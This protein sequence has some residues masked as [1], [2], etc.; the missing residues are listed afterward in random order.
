MLDLATVIGAV[1]AREVAINEIASVTQDTYRLIANIEKIK[2]LG[3][4]PRVSISEG[5]RQLVE[6]LGDYPELPGGVTIFAKGR[7]LNRETIQSSD[8]A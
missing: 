1:T 2:A 6:Q 7:L 3:Y 4:V 5:V 8:Q